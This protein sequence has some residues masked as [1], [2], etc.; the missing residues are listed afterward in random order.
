MGVSGDFQGIE[1]A[2]FFNP[3]DE[4]DETRRRGAD[5]REGQALP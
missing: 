3:A 5:L 4:C 1:A 2:W